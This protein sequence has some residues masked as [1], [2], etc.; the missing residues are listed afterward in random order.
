M[1]TKDLKKLLQ[2]LNDHMTQALEGAVGFCISRGHYEV[3]TEHLLLKLME[4]GSGDVPLILNHFEVNTSK[5][6][7]DLL[8]RLEGMKTGNSGRPSFSPLMLQVVEAAWVV[9]SVHHGYG[10]IRSGALLEAMLENDA[11]RATSFFDHLEDVNRDELRHNF[12]DIV[13]GSAED[14][15]V[16]RTSPRPRMDGE[17][18]GR[19]GETALDLYT[20]DVTGNARAGDID[21]VFGRDTEIRQIIDILSRRRKNNPILVGEP[22]VGKTAVV[23]GLALRIAQGDVP[24]SLKEVE[25]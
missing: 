13:G 1:I 5:L 4:D 21:P 7:E 10:E 2:K 25:I 12:I 18:G 3:T 16:S 8:D 19:E 14:K 9:S 24:D 23:E 11:M 20:H 22:G 6:W 17:A 15:M